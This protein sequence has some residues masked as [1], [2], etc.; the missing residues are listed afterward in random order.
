MNL[1]MSASPETAVRSALPISKFPSLVPSLVVSSGTSGWTRRTK[2]APCFAKQTAG[3]TP[4]C[5]A[6]ATISSVRRPPACPPMLRSVATTASRAAIDTK[7]DAR[8]RRVHRQI[9]DPRATQGLPPHSP[10]RPV[11]QSLLRRQHSTRAL[12]GAAKPDGQSTAAIVNHGKPTCP[13]Y[14]GRMIVIEVFERGCNATASADTTT[15]I[16]LDTS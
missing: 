10:L 16:R 9:P 1:R 15:V 13:C 6:A 2:S 8:H 4:H 12:L 14:G 11:R 5:L 3:S 7:H